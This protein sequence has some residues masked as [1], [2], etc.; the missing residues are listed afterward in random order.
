MLYFQQSNSNPTLAA[1]RESV[2]GLETKL[3]SL[4]NKVRGTS[5]CLV[6]SKALVWT[7][8]TYCLKKYEHMDV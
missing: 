2:M 4:Q 5:K 7:L 3:L 1:T 8:G 6:I